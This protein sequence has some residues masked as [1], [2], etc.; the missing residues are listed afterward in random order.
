M[1]KD[2]IQVDDYIFE[3]TLTHLKLVSEKRIE[4]CKQQQARLIKESGKR[5]ALWDVVVDMQYLTKETVDEVLESYINHDFAPVTYAKEKGK[6]DS[7]RMPTQDI[8]IRSEN[9]H[10]ADVLF[11]K[12]CVSN[13]L[14]TVDLANSIAVKVPVTGKTRAW[15]FALQKDILKDKIINKVL[16]KLVTKFPLKFDGV[17]L[18]DLKDSN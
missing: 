9:V 12:T 8:K 11:L 3:R 10:K 17:A 16:N 6:A 5:V 13:N 4:E 15:D 1:T 18:P 2:E 7:T 14:L